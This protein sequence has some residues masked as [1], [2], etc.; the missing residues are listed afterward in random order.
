MKLIVEG[1]AKEIA[2]LVLAVQ[3]RQCAKDMYE[4]YLKNVQQIAQNYAD[5]LDMEIRNASDAAQVDQNI[6]NK[7]CEGIHA[8]H[9]ITVTI[10]RIEALCGSNTNTAPRSGF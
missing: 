3:E 4:E 9:E 10:G 7:V 1:E 6:F 5:L 2:A 8:L